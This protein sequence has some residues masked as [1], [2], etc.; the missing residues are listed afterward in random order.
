MLERKI[1]STE[2]IL[3]NSLYN[4]LFLW[5]CITCK[6][7]L[8]IHDTTSCIQL[9]KVNNFNLT[10]VCTITIYKRLSEYIFY[11]NFNSNYYNFFL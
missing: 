4:W 3:H 1:K 6:I 10:T 8:R 7:L 11:K 9:K 5:P 2:Y